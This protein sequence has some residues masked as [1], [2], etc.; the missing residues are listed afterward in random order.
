MIRKLLAG[1][2]VV[3]LVAGFALAAEVKSGPQPGEKIP[4]P[5]TPLNV[6]GE[7]AGQKKCLVCAKTRWS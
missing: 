2:P 7:G 3:A 1:V 6:T 4:G 5:F